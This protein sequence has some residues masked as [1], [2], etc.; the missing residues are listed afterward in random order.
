LLSAVIIGCEPGEELNGRFRT[1]L[2]QSAKNSF[3][4]SLP[5]RLCALTEAELLG[6]VPSEL[7]SN[8]DAPLLGLGFSLRL[9]RNLARS[10]QGNLQFQKEYLLLTLP[11]SKTAGLILAGD[12]RE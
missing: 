4:L 3:V 7:D 9:V 11:A 2:G 10:V 5:K 8:L 6:S 12:E 1:E